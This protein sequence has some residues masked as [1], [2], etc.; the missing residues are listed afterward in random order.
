MTGSM[1][2]AEALPRCCVALTRLVSFLDPGILLHPRGSPNSDI[3]GL[4]WGCGFIKHQESG[5]MSELVAG[6]S[7]L[8][9]PASVIPIDSFLHSCTPCSLPFSFT[10]CLPLCVPCAP[11]FPSALLAGLCPVLV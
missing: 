6:A 9:L 3:L 11:T 7:C 1:R 8:S 2:P 10:H 5:E 4:S